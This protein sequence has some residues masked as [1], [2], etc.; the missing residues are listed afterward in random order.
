MNK[1]EMK[2]LNFDNMTPEEAVDIIIKDIKDDSG[3]VVPAKA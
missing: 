3:E 1:S 2:E